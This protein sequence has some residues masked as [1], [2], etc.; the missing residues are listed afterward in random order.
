MV[1]LTKA[2]RLMGNSM[3]QSHNKEPVPT[4]KTWMSSIPSTKNNV[5]SSVPLM[6]V[7]EMTLPC[8]TAWALTCRASR[9]LGPWPF[10][11]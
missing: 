1:N 4:F 2:Q 8:C 7:I 9:G 5:S 6:L 3:Q 10:P 11:G